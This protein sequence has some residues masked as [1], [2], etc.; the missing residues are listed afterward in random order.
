[1]D[2]KILIFVIRKMSLN[3]LDTRSQPTNNNFDIQ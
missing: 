2:K 3:T 1:M